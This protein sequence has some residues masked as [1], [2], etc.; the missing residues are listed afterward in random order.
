MYMIMIW[1]AYPKHPR[2]L[3][4]NV[5]AQTGIRAH[6]HEDYA[7]EHGY[8][9]ARFKQDARKLS[10]VLQAVLVGNQPPN[11]E[12]LTPAAAAA[13][14]RLKPLNEPW[15]QRAMKAR[16]KTFAGQPLATRSSIRA[17]RH[18]VP[19]PF[20]D[21]RGQPRKTFEK[22]VFKDFDGKLKRYGT[23]GSYSN[24]YTRNAR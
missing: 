17:L 12:L 11:H 3:R 16:T 13:A 7:H 1:A 22:G 14:H 18:Q 15:Q 6:M 21:P 10:C 5:T 20:P 8:V 2:H 24:T 4:P 9:S 23:V 19:H